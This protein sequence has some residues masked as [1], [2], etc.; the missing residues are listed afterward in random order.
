MNL[1]SLKNIIYK[2]CFEIIYIIYMYKKDLVL[3][4]LQWLVYH[5]TKL[6]SATIPVQSGSGSNGNEGV[7]YIPQWILTIR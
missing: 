1:G 5:K 4:K 6:N 3:N 2:M 7:F